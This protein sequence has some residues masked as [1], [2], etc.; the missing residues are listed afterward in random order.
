MGG[1][2]VELRMTARE[3]EQQE[4]RNEL[5]NNEYPIR[6]IWLSLD[7]HLRTENVE[8]GIFGSVSRTVEFTWFL[9]W[10]RSETE[11]AN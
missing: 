6:G 10:R 1:G 8:F 4:Q 2:H 11:L 7:T 3:R 9:S 5:A